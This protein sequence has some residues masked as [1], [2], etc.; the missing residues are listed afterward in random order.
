MKNWFGPLVASC[1]LVAV[2]SFL[3]THRRQV[4]APNGPA[5]VTEHQTYAE[6]EEAR[7][8]VTITG[9]MADYMRR[10]KVE[11]LQSVSAMSH[12]TT[13]S[14]H[15]AASSP[16]GTST[17]LLRKTFNVARI[18]DLPF[19]LP[20]HAANPQLRGTYSSFTPHSGVQQASAHVSDTTNDVDF[21]VLNEGQY[22]DLLSGR[23]ADALFSADGAPTQE[24]NFTMPPTFDRPLKY[25]L[26]FRN[27]SP[28]AGNRAVKADFRID[29]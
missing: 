17:P 15:V 8:A 29:F 28:D 14:E 12:Q 23:P 5:V 1:V 11:T 13:A 3:W 7:K 20:A 24:I 10:Q 21:L 19:E 2:G 18:V 27:G 22:V 6:E 16:V 9:P 25:H 4:A 26:V